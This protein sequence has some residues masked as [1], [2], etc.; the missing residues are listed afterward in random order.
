MAWMNDVRMLGNKA[1]NGFMAGAKQAKF[2]AT[3]PAALEARGIASRLANSTIGYGQSAFAAAGGARSLGIKAGV[4]A[5]IGAAGGAGYSY[6][7]DG[8]VTASSMIKGALLGAAGGAGYG[9]YGG[10]RRL[11]GPSGFGRIG[12]DISGLG[13]RVRRGAYGPAAASSFVR[14]GGTA[15]MHYP[16]GDYIRKAQ[17][18]LGDGG[19]VRGGYNANLASK[20][21]GII[22]ESPNYSS[23]RMI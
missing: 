8:R 2:Y 11:V 23:A 10:A 15:P 19:T 5:G 17:L 18:L 14:T 12:A 13:S 21:A 9:M 4:G 3:S 7:D 22:R 20:V 16:T 6:A 1:L